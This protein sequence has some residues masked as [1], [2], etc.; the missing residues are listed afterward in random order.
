MNQYKKSLVYFMLVFLLLVQ[1]IISVDVESKINEIGENTQNKVESKVSESISNKI[2]ESTQQLK[3]SFSD[4]LQETWLKS[5]KT[6]KI[7]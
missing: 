3:Q 4:W 7:I 5:N 1:S 2:D 6:N